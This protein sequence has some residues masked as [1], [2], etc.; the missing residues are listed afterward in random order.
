[1]KHSRQSPASQRRRSAKNL[2]HTQCRYTFVGT[3]PTQRGSRPLIIL[4]GNWLRESGF[5]FSQR[6]RIVASQGKIVLEPVNNTE[7]RL[8]CADF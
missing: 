6:L 4:H 1:M 5:G 2:R 7:P 3:L 8:R